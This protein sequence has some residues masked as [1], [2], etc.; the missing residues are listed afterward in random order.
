MIN[1]MKR[2]KKLFIQKNKMKIYKNNMKIQLNKMQNKIHRF[3]Y[4]KKIMKNLNNNQKK[5]KKIFRTCKYKY[6]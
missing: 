6:K 5:N 4:L 3:N 1:Q 2:I